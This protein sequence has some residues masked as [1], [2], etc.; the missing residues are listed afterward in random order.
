MLR[1][2]CTLAIC[3]DTSVAN[4]LSWD[5]SQFAIRLQT[6]PGLLGKASQC[7][8]VGVGGEVSTVNKLLL[9]GIACFGYI[10]F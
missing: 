9:R 6:Q 4:L 10:M 5:S 1:N 7:V 2:L 3:K 8:G